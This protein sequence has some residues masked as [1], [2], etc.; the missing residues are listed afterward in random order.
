MLKFIDLV[1]LQRG[2]HGKML[3]DIVSLL[4]GPTNTFS[5]L[6][7]KNPGLLVS[8]QTAAAEVSP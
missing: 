3:F 4:S 2:L 5:S 7:L 8:R 1:S 6:E